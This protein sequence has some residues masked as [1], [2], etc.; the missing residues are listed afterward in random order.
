MCGIPAAGDVWA[1]S[2]G[3]AARGASCGRAET[4]LYGR[5]DRPG[6]PVGRACSFRSATVA[7]LFG[8]ASL[9][10]PSR[11]QAQIDNRTVPTT[12]YKAALHGF[13]YQG[14]YRDALRQFQ[15][16]W[17]GAVKNVQT[18][19]IDSICYHTLIGECYYEMGRLDEALEHYT[20]ALRLYRRFSD[21]MIRVQFPPAI[22]PSGTRIH[23]PWGVSSRRT[24]VGYYPESMLIGQGQILTK[25][26]LL[27]GGPIAPP[28][29]FP[30]DPQEIVRCTALAIRRRTELLGPLTQYDPMTSELIG[31]LSQRPSLPNHWSQCWI[32]VLLG[33]AMV[34]GGKQKEAIPLLTRG[35]VA[36][37]EFDH[38]LTSTALLE[39]GRLALLRGDNASAMKFFHEASISAAYYGDAGVLE[40]AFRLAA[41]AHLLANRKG[42]YPPLMPAADW[43]RRHDLRQLWVSLLLS[44]AEHWSVL[45]QTDQAAAM[46]DQAQRAVGLRT[47][48]AGRIGARL[49]FLRAGVLFQQRKLASG[50]KAVAAAMAF[51]RHGS[52]WLNQIAQLDRRFAAGQITTRGP[53]TARA[54]MELYGRLLGDPTPADWALRPMES[55][56]VLVTPHVPS[57]EHWFLVALERKVHEKALEIADLA[58]R[59]RFFSSLA[60]GG[61][62]QSLRWILE[63]PDELIGQDGLL[64]RQNLLAQYPAY[65]ALKQQADAV[66]A[67]LAAMPL[68]PDDPETAGKQRDA[69]Q[70]LAALSTLEEAVLR[71]MAVRREPAS[72]V[73]P[74]VRTTKQIQAA[75]P[76]G[77]AI[78]AFF[79]AKGNLYGFLLNREKYTYWRLQQ[80]HLLGPRIVR[81]LSRMGHHGQ[82]RQLSLTDLEDTGWQAA[83]SE[84]LAAILAGSRV[85]LT[86]E[87]PELVIVPDSILWYVPFE[88]LPVEADGQLEPLITRFRIRYAPT[89]SLAVTGDHRRRLDATTAVVVGQLF[90]QADE[91]IGQAAFR[92]LA[93]VVPRCVPLPDEPPLPGPS[94]VYTTLMDQLIVLDDL[95]PGNGPYNWA[96]LE[97]ERSKPGNTLSDWLALPWGG[98][99]VVVLPGF[100]TAAESALR[101][102]NQAAPG[103]EIFLTICGLL[104]TGARTL[105]LARWRTGGQTSYDLVREFAQELPHTAP[106]AA[107]Q[108]AV[109]LTMDTPLDLERE[110]RITRVAVADPP[111]AVHPFFWAGYLLV[112]PGVRPG[113]EQRKRK[114]GEAAADQA[115]AAFEPRA[116]PREGIRRF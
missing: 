82:D 35:A 59:H 58:R 87:F 111:E 41:T 13:F 89:I 23:I 32:D 51:M 50:D 12:A 78:L 73:F 36:A 104:S 3:R 18:R 91:A 25:E 99:S 49:Q 55:L 57:Y 63:A 92:D 114:Q 115:A 77:H 30:I 100:H 69:L 16:E 112:D 2:L 109:L 45:G 17:R 68:V 15:Q 24:R 108:R 14:E 103:Q 47:M 79:L 113:A 48:G 72:L 84:L 54:A 8:L 64:H 42:V 102:V 56:S 105:L 7:I 27:Q 75:L 38:V 4:I 26:R 70:R 95:T 96:L 116:A 6:S 10:A 46:L 43:A 107:W 66:R 52:K 19:W 97:A 1:R 101:G 34:A 83:A 33:L 71:E 110:P 62:L 61:R 5:A 76:E 39:L 90:P 88:A 37:G 31:V 53:I 40:E 93:R 80:T 9:V 86:D 44:A 94:S 22:R 85:D 98:P 60:Y 74:P 20:A 106:A 11:A 65:A 67:E 28:V 21:W 81:L 29:L